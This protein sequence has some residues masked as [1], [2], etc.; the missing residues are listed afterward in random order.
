[1]LRRLTLLAM[2]LAAM[3]PGKG[4]A[5]GPVTLEEALHRADQQGFAN[6]MATAER[7]V[8][9]GEA[10]GAWRGILPTVRVE[11]GWMRTTDPLNAFGFTLRQRAVTPAAFDPARLNNPPA[12]TNVG[13]ALVLEQPLLNLDAWA[14]R[15]AGSAAVQAAAASERWA[16][17]STRVNVFRAW[18]GGVLAREKVTT[19][20]AALAAAESHVR[21]AGLM[22]EQ[23]MVTRADL[24]LAQVKSGEVRADLIAAR[25]DLALATRQLAMVLGTPDDT[26]LRI[27]VA[28]PDAQLLADVL[29]DVE[30]MEG[31]PLIRA[32][33][34]AA[35]LGEQAARADLRRTRAAMLPRLNGFARY[36]WNTAAAVYSG[37]ESWTVG[38]MAS[39]S[40]FSGGAEL[41]ASRAAR[42][43][44]EMAA[45]GAEAS[46]AKASLEAAERGNALAVARER[47]AI[48][49]EAVAQSEE[50]HRLVSRS[51]AGGLAT[52][53]ELLGAAAA[54]TGARLAHAAAVY[55]VIVAAAERQQALGLSLDVLIA[56]GR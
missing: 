51:Y 37:Q 19:L 23:G 25:G 41:A 4:S 50:A 20:A 28:L 8:R 53:T 49:S 21:Q 42:G 56:L 47:L 27:P 22:L 18:F 33:V 29:A 38:V 6:R 15:G 35:R 14:G 32:D 16:A 52:I 43:R 10:G 5:Q 1:M 55:Q 9:Q 31:D 3:A 7:R 13:S 34:E 44:A 24:L 45:A 54:E 36:D 17:T 30:T 11:A 39:W 2:V 40:P 48:S 26:T 12:T 46:V